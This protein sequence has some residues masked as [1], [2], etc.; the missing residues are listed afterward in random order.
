MGRTHTHADRPPNIDDVDHNPR[1]AGRQT[2]A[3]GISWEPSF[4]VPMTAFFGATN[5]KMLPTGWSPLGG[6]LDVCGAGRGAAR[7]E[8]DQLLPTNSVSPAPRT[9]SAEWE[10]V[11]QFPHDD[12]WL[13]FPTAPHASP[14]CN[15]TSRCYAGSHGDPLD[16]WRREERERMRSPMPGAGPRVRVRA[17]GWRTR[18]RLGAVR[19]GSSSRSARLDS[20]HDHLSSQDGRARGGGLGLLG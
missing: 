5:E 11:R 3:G 2:A 15:P 8:H 13:A 4:S 6:R 18:R 9:D 19:A 20:L 1:S 10:T 7:G 17:K 12:P 16:P 14:T